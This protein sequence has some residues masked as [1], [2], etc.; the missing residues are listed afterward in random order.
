MNYQI[1][2]TPAFDRAAKRLN[3]KFRRLKEDLSSLAALLSDNPFAGVAIPGFSHSVWKIRLASTDM[4]SGKRGGYRVIYAVDMEMYR[5]ILLY[6]YA[7]AERTTMS[8][9]EIEQ[10]LSDID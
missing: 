8:Q 6:I 7:K 2:T 4:Q 10:L 5:C 3:K 1:E 9:A